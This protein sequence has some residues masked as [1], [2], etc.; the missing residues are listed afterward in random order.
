MKFIQTSFWFFGKP[1]ITRHLDEKGE[2]LHLEID[3]RKDHREYD[4]KLETIKRELETL[5][6]EIRE[7]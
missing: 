5:K 4:L 2:N 1:T 3:T 7:G 6:Q